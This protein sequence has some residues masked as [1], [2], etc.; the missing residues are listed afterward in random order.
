[1]KAIILEDEIPALEKLERSNDSKEV[2]KKLK[3][4]ESF[5]STQD[6]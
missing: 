5:N 2:R 1:M 4:I 6:F 3:K